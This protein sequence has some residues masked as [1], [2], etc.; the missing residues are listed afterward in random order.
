MPNVYVVNIKAQAYALLVYFILQDENNKN[1]LNSVEGVGLRKYLLDIY[2]P[3]E[4]ACVTLQLSDEQLQLIN[5][6]VSSFTSKMEEISRESMMYGAFTLFMNDIR[7]L[8]LKRQ[9][10]IIKNAASCSKC[11][12]V[13]A[14]ILI[15]CPV[16]CACGQLEINGGLQ[17]LVRRGAHTELSEF[18]DES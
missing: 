18:L 7:S 6:L 1:V 17:S 16:E 13:L 10:R 3:F 8:K 5:S 15:D 4:T 2:K 14:S 12:E 9:K 11:N